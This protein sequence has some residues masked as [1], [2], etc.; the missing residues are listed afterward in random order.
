L[1]S[2]PTSFTPSGFGRFQVGRDILRYTFA[3]K[4][5]DMGLASRAEV[6]LAEARERAAAARRQ[7]RDGIDPLAAKQE[8]RQALV[9]RK[10]MTFDQCARAYVL[11]HQ[12][13][14]RN[15]KHRAQWGSSLDTYASPIFGG[16]NVARVDTAMV[17]QALGDIWKTKTETASRVRGRIEAVLDWAKVA[18]YRDGE[19]PA[20]WKGHL[21]NLLAA[22]RRIAK[23]E[24]RRCPIGKSAPSSKSCANSRASG[25]RRWNLPS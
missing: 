23:I 22:P 10:V 8:Q 13:S 9:A 3:G 12:V 21:E 18:G 25:R 2:L 15:P 16:I 4:R 14:W 24:H 17:V 7:L 5:R 20:R 19:N 11:A 1:R 6:G